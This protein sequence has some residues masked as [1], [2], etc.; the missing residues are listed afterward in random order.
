LAPLKWAGTIVALVAVAMWRPGATP[1]P[2][3]R[4][5]SRMTI[6]LTFVG[7]GSA[8]MGLLLAAV[9][10]GGAIPGLT[11]S[12]VTS[13]GLPAW[14]DIAG[15]LIV[16]AAGAVTLLTWSGR[17]GW[18]EGRRAAVAGGLVLVYA[19]YGITQQSLADHP[20][21]VDVAGNVVLAL[22][23]AGLAFVAVRRATPRSEECARKP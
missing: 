7:L 5:P 13:T 15:L 20:H 19:W 11:V 17:L 8:F 22:A 14:L 10:F 21:A 16:L 23:A 3:R 12:E 2:S 18:D 1:Q 9:L 6:S 4:P